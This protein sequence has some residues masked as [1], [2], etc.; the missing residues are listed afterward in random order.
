MS[1]RIARVA[2]LLF[3]AL[4]ALVVVGC[5]VWGKKKTWPF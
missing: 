3:L 5:N 2:S 1:A 4:S